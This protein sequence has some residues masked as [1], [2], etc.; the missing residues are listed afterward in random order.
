MGRASAIGML[1]IVG[2]CTE[3][4]GHPPI[5]RIDLVPAAIPAFDNFQTIVELDGSTSAD[6]VDDPAGKA[7]LTFTWEVLDTESK[8]EMGRA[9]SASPKL[10]FLGDRPPTIVLTVTDLDGQDASATASLALTVK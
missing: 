10:R 5:A 4:V 7:A 1:L 3:P 6:P 9:T 2:A 8:F